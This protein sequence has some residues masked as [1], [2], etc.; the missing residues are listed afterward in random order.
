MPL[1]YD[2]YIGSDNGSKRLS[3]EYLNQILEWADDVFPDGYT[4]VKSEGYSKQS[5]EESLVM[6]TIS[7][8]E[9]EISKEIKSLKEKLGQDAI[10]VTRYGV[11][12]ELV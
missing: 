5:R 4:I 1:R 11:E 9:L 6:S 8:H 3:E 7:K 10:L 2:I 12:A